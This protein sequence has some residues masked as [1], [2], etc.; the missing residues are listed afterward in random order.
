MIFITIFV[1][2][3]AHRAFLPMIAPGQ[4]LSGWGGQAE[5]CRFISSSE[6]SQK[7]FF[8]FEVGLRTGVEDFTA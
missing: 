3:A 6:F 5:S 2:D 8:P 4:E 7:L 1:R